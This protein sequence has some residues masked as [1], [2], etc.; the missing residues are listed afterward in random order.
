[1]VHGS[2]LTLT[3]YTKMQ[4]S[5]ELPVPDELKALIQEYASDKAG[6]A[7]TA[8]LIKKLKFSDLLSITPCYLILQSVTL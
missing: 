8:H 7:P 4:Q 2:S 3:H 6:V 1:M 5:Q